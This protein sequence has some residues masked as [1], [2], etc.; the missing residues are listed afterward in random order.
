MRARSAF[1]SPS[2]SFLLA[3]PHTTK[4][5]EAFNSGAYRCVAQV[6]NEVVFAESPTASSSARHHDLGQPGQQ[7]KVNELLS[8][9]VTFDPLFNIV[10]P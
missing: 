2:V 8:L 3:R 9:L 6:M 4:A 1:I 5:R 10:T 7:E